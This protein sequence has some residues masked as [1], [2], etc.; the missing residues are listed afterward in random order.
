[1]QCSYMCPGWMFSL[2]IFG[3]LSQYATT[4]QSRAYLSALNFI[5]GLRYVRIGAEVNASLSL[6]SA[7]CSF[8]THDKS[9]IQIG[10]MHHRI[11]NVFFFFIPI[12]F[13]FNKGS[14]VWH[15]H[16]HTHTYIQTYIHNYRML[17]NAK[18]E[19]TIEWLSVWN[20]RCCKLNDRINVIKWNG[21]CERWIQR[22]SRF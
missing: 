3:W 14:F 19:L 8:H 16:T 20:E 22:M 21:W 13:I 11:N 15:T 12:S 18:N 10:K 17:L 7:T 2:H 4:A 1:M 6:S 9:N 5:W